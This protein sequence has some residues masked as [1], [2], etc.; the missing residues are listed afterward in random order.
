[1][2]RVLAVVGLV[3][4]L[5]AC[6]SSRSAIPFDPTTAPRPSVPKLVVVLDD[7]GLKLS[8]HKISAGAHLISFRDQR[9]QPP[10]GQHVELQLGPSGPL[11]AIVSVP[12]GSQRQANLLQNEIPW[13]AINGVANHRVPSEPLEIE[14]TKQF[15][16]AAT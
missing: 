9:S 7:G 6:H 3:V 4:A 1:M 11:I 2:K 15:P 13:I 10:P 5:A 14:P 16:T 12:A 8:A